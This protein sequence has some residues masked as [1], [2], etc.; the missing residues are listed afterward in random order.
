MRYTHEDT[1][2]NRTEG[3]RDKHQSQNVTYM[4]D[5]STKHGATRGNKLNEQE[6]QN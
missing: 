3:A 5:M 1:E 6:I 2:Q 4:I